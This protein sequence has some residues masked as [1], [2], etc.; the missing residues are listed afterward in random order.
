MIFE[1]IGQPASDRDARVQQLAELGFRWANLE[2]EAYWIDQLIVMEHAV[3]EEL[4]AAAKKLWLVFDKAARSLIGYRECYAN[5]SIP[6]VL[7]DGLD[8]LEPGEEGVISR[9]A[10]FDF[11]I[12]IEGKI[13]LLELNADTPTGYVEA[14]I[15]T[16][17]LCD[18]YGLVSPNVEMKELV[19]QAWAIEAPTYAAC[20][21]Y[22][23]HIEDTGT[24]DALVAHSQR[25]MT[26]VN[27][28]D[29]WI[30]DGIVK[31][32]KDQTIQRMFALY[33]KEW[34]GVD[35]G[36]EAL[37]YAIEEQL[38]QLFNPL[39]AVILQSKGLQALI[40]Q[41]HLERSELF[42]EEEHDAIAAYMLPTFTEPH[43][44]GNYVS[45]S[46]FG[47]EGGSVEIYDE[48]GELAHK[49][50]AGFDTSVFFKRVYQGRAD[51]PELSFAHGQGHLL[52]GLFVLN[53]TPCG[54]LGR[55]GGLITGNAS[56]FVA[57]G[58][59]TP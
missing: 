45:K 41:L 42:T 47:R 4:I 57:I 12:N 54:L 23:Q 31:V 32:G 30:D 18:Q 52:T 10:R 13:K 34:M 28:L 11:S 25:E 43:L 21:G 49:D 35:D 16:P 14:A 58:V 26:C 33:P 24:I 55:A 8:R 50:E 15:A 44:E 59:K 6:E 39:H 2:E 5:L 48:H 40:W 3:Y 37:S 9:Y 22:G 53:G 36:G 19:R 17:W 46:M 7:W 27:C 38:V 20:V 29:V 1:V 56:Q 51:L